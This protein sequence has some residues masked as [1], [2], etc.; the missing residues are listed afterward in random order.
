MDQ[1]VTVITLDDDNRHFAET[2]GVSGKNRQHGFV[3]G[4]LDRATGRIYRACQADGSPSSVHTLDGLPD[5]L[6]LSR[7]QSGHVKMVKGTVLPGFI[8]DGQ[9]YTREQAA[10]CLEQEN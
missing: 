6:V 1:P 8:L 3:P 9:F 5:A 7:T 10:Q 2:G 4:F